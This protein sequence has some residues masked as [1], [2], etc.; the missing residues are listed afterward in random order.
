MGEQTGENENLVNGNKRKIGP[1]EVG[2]IGF[3]CWRF[4]NTDVG[5]ATHRIAHALDLGLTLV[6]NA[7]VYGLDWGGTAFGEAET[8]LGQVLARAP[9]LRERMVLASKGGILP[10]VPYVANSTYLS[11]ACDASLARLNTEHIDLYQIHRP[12]M[13]THPA[14]TAAALDG[15]VDAGK[16]SAVGVSNYTPA[17]VRA[18]AAHLK[19]P[20]VA[21]QCE[22][23]LANLA[24]LRDGNLDL[25]M[26]TGMVPLAWSPLGGGALM[27]STD[28]PPALYETC[29]RLAA[30]E[31]TDRAGLALAFVLAHPARPVALIGSQT[32]ARLTQAVNALEITLTRADVYALIEAREG[33][34]LP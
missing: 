28:L 32:P 6:D 22:Y 17:Q 12:D 34:P 5:T 7:D 3:G 23:S 4:V 25:C 9:E 33:V 2:P 14:E 1:F 15:L 24:M 26:E 21:L 19:A 11:S 8:L 31:N 16:I 13:L 29:D 30:R 10:G 18:L 20:L 27:T